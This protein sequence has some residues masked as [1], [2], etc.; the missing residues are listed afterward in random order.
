MK[1]EPPRKAHKKSGGGQNPRRDLAGVRSELIRMSR[2]C[3]GNQLVVLE[4]EENNSVV[5]PA[6][7]NY[8]AE[9]G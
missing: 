6:K 3:V 8:H 4:M 5:S 9:L 1:K 7:C 2:S